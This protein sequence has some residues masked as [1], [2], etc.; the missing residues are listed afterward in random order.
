MCAG[1]ITRFSNTAAE[2]RRDYS[3]L[4]SRFFLREFNCAR[5][6]VSLIFES[7]SCIN[8]RLI[9]VEFLFSNLFCFFFRV[10]E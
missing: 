2:S 1:R 6:C 9:Y 10:D 5:E 8:I 4:I 3:D 7:A